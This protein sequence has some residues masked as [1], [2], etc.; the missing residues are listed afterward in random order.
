MIWIEIPYL[1]FVIRVIVSLIRLWNAF[2]F[3]NNLVD[4]LKEQKF[5]IYFIANYIA[6]E[7]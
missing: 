4:S 7:I 6:I 2:I 1:I 5:V 3:Y